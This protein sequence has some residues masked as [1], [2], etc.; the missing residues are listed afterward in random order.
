MAW[1]KE[2]HAG[3]FTFSCYWMGTDCHSNI[4]M[5]VVFWTLFIIHCYCIHDGFIKYVTNLNCILPEFQTWL[6]IRDFSD[7][8]IAETVHPDIRASLAS[9]PGFAMS[10]GLSVI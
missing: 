3:F 1:T 4:G 5:D 6:D 7:V 8:Y 10:S 9:L 2:N